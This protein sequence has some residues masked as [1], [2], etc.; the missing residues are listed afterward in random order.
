MRSITEGPIHLKEF[1]SC[2]PSRSCGA[3]ASFV[4]IV[5]DHDRGRPVRKLIYDC[6]MSMADRVI[7]RL[8]D[9][10]KGRWDVD[11]VH[12]LHRVGELEIGEVAVAIAVS[13][14]HRAEAFSACRF[15]IEEMKIKVPIWKKEI[16]ADGTREWVSCAHAEMETVP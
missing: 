4:G 14:A 11:D 7:G 16:Y 13:S 1:F 2:A 12:V 3:L 15:M 6:Y 8:M 9:E 5:R 10:A